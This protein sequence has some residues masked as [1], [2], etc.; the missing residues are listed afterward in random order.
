MK[1]WSRFNYARSLCIY[2]SQLSN[3][4]KL[5]IRENGTEY[6]QTVEDLVDVMKITVP[7]NNGVS[8]ANIVYGKNSVI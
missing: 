7:A 4:V 2:F 5:R 8:E 6:V 3:S 1:K